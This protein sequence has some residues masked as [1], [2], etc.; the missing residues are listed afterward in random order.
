MIRKHSSLSDTEEKLLMRCDLGRICTIDRDGYPH[1]VRVDYVYDKG[2]IL[3]GS[4]VSRKWHSHLSNNPKVAFEVDI[5][6]KTESGVID[7]RGLMVK[8]RAF[9][10]EDATGR[11]EATALLKAKHPGAPFGDYPI[12]VRVVPAK[13]VRWGPWEKLNGSQ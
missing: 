12:I 5:Y 2:T 7:F 6:E 4:Q 3:V 8:G 10:V 9:L 13:R 11:K 1:C